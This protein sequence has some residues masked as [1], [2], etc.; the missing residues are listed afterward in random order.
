M[1]MGR[2]ML[3]KWIGCGVK[4]RR[5]QALTYAW[6]LLGCLHTEIAAGQAQGVHGYV[7]SGATGEALIGTHVYELRTRTGVITNQYGFFRLSAASDT[8]TVLISHVGYER[9]MISLV[10]T[11]SVQTFQLTPFTT[12]LD[13]MVVIAESARFEIEDRLLTGKTTVTPADVAMLSALFGEADI[14]KVFQLKPG[15]S[16]GTEGTTG[17]H[18]RGGSPDQNLIIM[19]G[20]PI[21][22]SSHLFGFISSFNHDALNEVELYKGGFPARY[23]GRLSSVVNL[24]M[25][26]GNRHE[27][28][29]RGSVGLLASRVTV[30]GPLRQNQS[31]FIVSAR[32]TYLDLLLRPYLWL[33]E[34][35]FQFGYYFGDINAKAN[36]ILSDRDHAFVSLYASRDNYDVQE[37]F[38]NDEWR[39]GVGWGNL[40]GTLRWNRVLRPT[41]FLNV[42][43]LHSSYRYAALDRYTT[44]V[45]NSE[46]QASE[47]FETKFRSGIADWT[48]KADVEYTPSMT[49]KLHFGASVS[50]KIYTP[51]VQRVLEETGSRTVV[52]T[53]VETNSKL[54][55]TEWHAYL[56]DAGEFLE[57]LKVN[58]GIHMSGF[59]AQGK[60]YASFEPRFSALVWIAPD[61]AA[62][63]SYARAFQYVHLLTNSG[64]GPPTD[65]WVPSTKR[66]APQ[67]A[68]QVS[69]GVSRH[70]AR[71]AI[72]ASITGYYK[73]M[74]DVIEYLEG[75]SLVGLNRDWESQVAAGRGWSYGIE[76]L[77]EKKEGKT[78]GWIGYTLSWSNRRIPDIN[79]GRTFPYRY[80][81]RHDLS[82]ALVRRLGRR[83]L[84]ATWIFA[85][86]DAVTIPV[87]Q[88]EESGTL[89]S[90]FVER[91]Q[92]RMP[93]YHRLDLSLHSP[94]RKG[95]AK[96]TFSVYNLY[97]RRNA[98]YTYVRDSAE[99][100][101]FRGYY[102]EARNFRKVSIF[103]VMPSISYSFTF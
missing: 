16:F 37:A 94:R 73:S 61:W 64:V 55:A 79:Q 33:S 34:S 6:I 71:D 96:L 103:P 80:D 63:A 43:L 8:F 25:R 5:A 13:S 86:G 20:A 89:V 27:F 81:R 66:V 7:I 29:G 92:Q 14:L 41:M 68:W 95:K 77:I 75:S 19:D 78:H 48:A 90:V 56:E 87:S 84:S 32:R 17:L 67:Q 52:D 62:T 59:H 102:D 54:A 50:R 70:G 49:H 93:A 39:N 69:A 3:E 15:V 97:N 91:N 38:N 100:D 98:F 45:A 46:S 40:L 30:E 24:T 83:T 28:E 2:V 51:G 31:S 26:E 88:Y 35:D 65:L 82:V 53:L 74:Q 99:Y 57:H 10:P 47:L 4:V 9:L 101:P 85:T 58:G 76:A 72:D 1:I 42:A 44:N 11:D 36:V 60:G 22:N 18:V 21:Y 12:P 23:G